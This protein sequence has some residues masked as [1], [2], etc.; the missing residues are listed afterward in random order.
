MDTGPAECIVEP[1]LDNR[2]E[3]T[4][5]GN[6]VQYKEVDGRLTLIESHMKVER[7]D[8]ELKAHDWRHEVKMSPLLDAYHDT[9]V[10]AVTDCNPLRMVVW[11]Q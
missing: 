5:E 2:L 11:L 6:S 8:A 10:R 9:F 7:E 1:E 3:P 4:E